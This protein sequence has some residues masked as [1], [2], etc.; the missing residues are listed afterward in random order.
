MFYGITECPQKTSKFARSQS[1]LKAILSTVPDI[2]RSAFKDVYHL[3]KFKPDQQHPR[4]LLIQVF[5]ALD[6]V[7]IL[8]NRSKL[9]PPVLAKFDMTPEKRKTESILLKERWNLI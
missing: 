2:E 5:C 8:S 4:P 6:A 1:N 7:A 9:S 3:G